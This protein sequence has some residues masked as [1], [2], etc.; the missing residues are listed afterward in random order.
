MHVWGSM[1][2]A[3]VSC[4]YEHLTAQ[5]TIAAYS[6]L[7]FCASCL[8]VYSCLCVKEVYD[9][10]VKAV[11]KVQDRL[12]RQ[13]SPTHDVC[14][15]CKAAGIAARALSSVARKQRRS[16]DDIS[17]IVANLGASCSCTNPPA[18]LSSATAGSSSSLFAS[19]STGGPHD[20]SAQHSDSVAAGVQLHSSPAVLGLQQP[21][22]AAA[23][24]TDAGSSQMQQHPH[25]QE[26][27]TQQQ[28]L[29]RPPK[30]PQ[31]SLPA[32]RRL[33]ARPPPQHL[34]RAP[35]AAAGAMHG[36]GLLLQP[37]VCPGPASAVYE[38]SA[39]HHHNMPVAS[40]ADGLQH[41]LLSDL[42]MSSPFA[43]ML[44]SAA[45]AEVEVEVDLHLD[46]VSPFSTV[47]S[48]VTSGG[49]APPALEFV[50]AALVPSGGS[51]G[52]R[53]RSLSVALGNS[54]SCGSVGAPPLGPLSSTEPPVVV[55]T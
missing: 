42:A 24:A 28:A 41:S 55:L 37:S 54:R 34:K 35:G 1:T 32:A 20:G 39:H 36:A 14:A 9:Y 44:S 48:G 10:A 11:H 29:F 40:T 7:L 21:T 6:L 16:R 33:P 25:Q 4:W 2:Q 27:H 51:S 5:A 50:A 52:A 15:G 45:V 8:C 12:T 53:K 17:V 3:N 13:R 26:Q 43:M 31:Q 38:A 49:S 30:Q 19:S 22:D 46:L 47:G 18:T 23:A